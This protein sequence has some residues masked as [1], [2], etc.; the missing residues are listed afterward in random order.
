MTERSTAPGKAERPKW[1][2][3]GPV[4]PPIDGQSKVTAAVVEILLERL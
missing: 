4:P 1:L 3:I 2:V